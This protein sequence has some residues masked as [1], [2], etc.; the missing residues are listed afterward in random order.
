MQVEELAAKGDA[1][2]TT[3]DEAPDYK[4]G[5]ILVNPFE[6]IDFIV[7]L[8]GTNHVPYLQEDKEVENPRHMP[9]IFSCLLLYN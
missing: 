5:N 6:N 9:R 7:E 8:S 1:D 3:D 2:L 4:K